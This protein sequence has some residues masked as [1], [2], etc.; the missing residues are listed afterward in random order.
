[1][2]SCH[3][4]CIC[5]RSNNRLVTIMMIAILGWG[6]AACQRTHAS[7]PTFPYDLSSP[8]TT[9]T[10]APALIEISGITSP[11]NG[12]HL[13]AVQDEGGVLYYINKADG[14]LVDSLWFAG[15][16][17][18]E[19]ITCVHDTLYVAKSNGSLYMIP[20][21]QRDTARTV[22]R[23]SRAWEYDYDIEGMA[24]DAEQRRLLMVAKA[25]PHAELSDERAIFAY[26]LLENRMLPEAVAAIR[27]QAFND[28][29]TQCGD[30]Q[31]F[32]K[33]RA[34]YGNPLEP[35]PFN[36]S[37]MAIH[38]I[39]RHW[40]ISAANGN[41]LIIM[42]ADG[43]ILHMHRLSRDIHLQPEG[44]WFDSNGDLYISNE[45]DESRPASVN[46]FKYHP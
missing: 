44:M 7:S 21:G 18:F 10:L 5:C 8:A 45:G 34:R 26:S 40:Y 22:I 32:E 16:G 38:P 1:M 28:Y 11:D 36:P 27:R 19:A 3:F 2:S 24:Y 14:Q 39:S 20:P 37:E 33:L 31:G 41:L 46:L 6:Q 15:K 42:Q 29:F 25:Q 30:C 23:L 43:K 4:R 12:R 13:V 35:F 17:D 9:W